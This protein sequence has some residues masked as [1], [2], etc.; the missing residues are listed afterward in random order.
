MHLPAAG[1][2]DVVSEV[3][4]NDCCVGGLDGFAVAGDKN[5]GDGLHNDD[6]LLALC[7]GVS[8]PQELGLSPPPGGGRTYLL[9]IEAA[10]IGSDSDE[11]FTSDGDTVGPSI[12][13]V[14]EGTGNTSK[15]VR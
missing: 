7:D 12:V 9:A 15:L 2:V 6:T 3:L 8:I 13:S 14:L 4:D 11:L 5:A 1:A 10:V